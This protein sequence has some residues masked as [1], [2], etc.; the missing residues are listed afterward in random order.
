LCPLHMQVCVCPVRWVRLGSQSHGG[1]HLQLTSRFAKKRLQRLKKTNM[2]VFG[3]L[4]LVFF[5]LSLV[6]FAFSV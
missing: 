6:F 1:F 4:S 2:V 5:S 3:S